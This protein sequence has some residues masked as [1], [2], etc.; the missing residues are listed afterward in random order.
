MFRYILPLSDYFKKAA[1]CPP[2][3]SWPLVRIIL[4]GISSKVT[5][6]VDA[7]DKCNG[8]DHSADLF[9]RL[10]KLRSV[11]NA[12]IIQLSRYHAALNDSLAMDL[13]LVTADISL[14]M[15]QENDRTISL[16][17]K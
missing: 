17:S 4:D 5:L 8:L 9:E 11:I 12:G 6:V 2:Y 7:L 14:C 15:K 1:E 3:N 10:T 16:Q 13:N